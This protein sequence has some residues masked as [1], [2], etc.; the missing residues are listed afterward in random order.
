MVEYALPLALCVV[1]VLVLAWSSGLLNNLSGQ[2]TGSVSGTRQSNRIAVNTF[3]NIPLPAAA[4]SLPDPGPGQESLCFLGGQTCLTIPIITPEVAGGLGGDS[5]K[6]LAMTLEE[7]AQLMREQGVDPAIVDLVTRLAN[8]GHGL[9]DEIKEIQALCP[10]TG[11]CVPPNS[12]Q[13]WGKLDTLHESKLDSFMADWN[14]LKQ[15][16]AQNPGALDKFPEALGIIRGQVEDIQ[17]LIKSLKANPQYTSINKVETVTKPEE[18]LVSTYTGVKTNGFRET[19]RQVVMTSAQV[20]TVQ[21]I[22]EGFVFTNPEAGR[23]TRSANNICSQGGQTSGQG[24]CLR[25]ASGST[26]WQ[27]VE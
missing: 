4:A 16:L 25:R 21:N 3:G 23:I 17:T 10:N 11:T 14:E 7:M 8:R 2:V 24:N 18:K 6:K 5:V 27:P 13:A 9:G 19:K 12:N 22:Q 1:V 26:E 15:L 20:T